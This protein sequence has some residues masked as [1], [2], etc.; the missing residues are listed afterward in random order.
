MAASSP[1]SSPRLPLLLGFG[2]LLCIMAIS[3]AGALRSLTA[4]RQEDTQIREQ[5]LLRNRLLNDIRAGVYL[6]GTHVRDYLLEPDSGRAASYGQSLS[7]VRERM[8]SDLAV[9]ANQLEPS[10]ST[11]YSTL[12]SQLTNYWKAIDPV[13]SWSAAR[14]HDA[15]YAYLR[16][17][18]FPRRAA[19]LDIAGE[20]GLLNEA[21]LQSGSTS[22][23]VRLGGFQ[24]RLGVTILA[25][26][27]LGLG[28]AWLSVRRILTAQTQ[29]SQRIKK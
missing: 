22:A 26:L 20:I 4:F 5:F 19:M 3:G 6:S 12:R 2:G 8:E 10:G 24:S 29:G 1:D 17:E 27:G 9:Y 15:G 21:Q 16:D 13:L 23:E 11:Q 7:S 25:A 14:R 18:V 28:M